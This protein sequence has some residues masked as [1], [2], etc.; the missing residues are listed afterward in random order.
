MANEFDLIKQYFQPLSAGLQHGDLGIGDDGAVL[1]VPAGHQLVVV[2]DTL[3]AGV[4]FPLETSAYDIA[5]KALAVNL[6]DLAAM[7]AKPGFFSL[8]LTL[9]ES[10]PLWL[11]EFARGLADLAEQF[12]I[13]LI[14]GDTTKGPLTVTVTAQG[15]VKSGSAVLRSGAKA[16]DVICVTNTIGD[17]A[18]GLKLVFNDFPEALST[19]LTEKEKVYLLKALNCPLPQLNA[20]NLLKRFANCAIDISDGLIADL[21]HILEASNSIE[22]GKTLSAHLELQDMPLSSAMQKYIQAIE[23][24][25]LVLTGGDDYQ[26]CF[27]VS[28]N[29]IDQLLSEAYE[30][31]ISITAIGRI[32]EGGGHQSIQLYQSGHPFSSGKI[33]SGY[34]HFK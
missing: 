29:E 24:W 32:E 18:L 33:G 9:P 2:T 15:W 13:P 25:S 34:L 12:K 1:S 10:D 27:T 19:S 20:V 26:L 16:R 8:A 31:N 5:W 22:A 30:S 21:S 7:G 14:G 4:H 3:V 6:S 11:K 23:D 17:G 28:E